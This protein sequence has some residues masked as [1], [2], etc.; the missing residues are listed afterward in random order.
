[1]RSRW[2]VFLTLF[3]VIGAALH[4]DGPV[5]DYVGAAFWYA[6]AAQQ[7]HL[8]ALGNLVDLRREMP[9]LVTAATQPVQA[10]ARRR[11]PRHLP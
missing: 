7:G 10:T 3:R 8:F 6:K 9:S 4:H 1:M 2:F 11:T 5:F